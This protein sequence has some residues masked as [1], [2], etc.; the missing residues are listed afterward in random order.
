MGERSW[1]E[2]QM[3]A[4]GYQREESYWT[5]EEGVSV[6]DVEGALESV[7]GICGCGRPEDVIAMVGA[8]LAL[9]A[10]KQK[11]ARDLTPLE[12]WLLYTLDRLGLTEHGVS[13]TGAWLT[14]KGKAF[15]ALAEAKKK[16]RQ[17]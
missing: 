3:K 5:D 13:V 16:E 7:L 1:L 12:W 10:Q 9:A 14:E 15:L 6:D 4:I 17:G 2:E 8:E 11:S